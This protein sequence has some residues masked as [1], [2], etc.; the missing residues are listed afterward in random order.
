VASE[1]ERKA[2]RVAAENVGGVREVH[3]HLR[4]LPPSVVELEAE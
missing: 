3:V 2:M 1:A 4:L